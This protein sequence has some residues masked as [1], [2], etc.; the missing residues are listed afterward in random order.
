[1]RAHYDSIH[2]RIASEWKLEG[3][4]FS[5]N[6]TIPANTTATVYLPVGDASAITESGQDLARAP[7]LKLLRAEGG[8]VVLV[9]ES[10]TYRFETKH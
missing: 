10:G 9:A 4:R 6:V 2:G 5:L 7:G 3:G 1:M 8:F